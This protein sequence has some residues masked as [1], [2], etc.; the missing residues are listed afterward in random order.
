MHPQYKN[1]TVN[2]SAVAILQIDGPLP[3]RLDFGAGQ[4]DAGFYR[5]LNKI[6][7]VGFLLVEMMRLPGIRTPSPAFYS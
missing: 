1:F 4:L 6:F 2:D 5:L 3:Q 7:V